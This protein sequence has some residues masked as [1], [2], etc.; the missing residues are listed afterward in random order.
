MTVYQD[1]DHWTAHLPP[2]WTADRDGD[3]SVLVDPAGPGV[4]QITEVRATEPIPDHKLKVAKFDTGEHARVI[5]L[6]WAGECLFTVCQ[7]QV[8]IH[9]A[10]FEGYLPR[11]DHRHRQHTRQM[12]V[13]LVHG[14]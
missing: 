14:S 7:S 9:L 11:I 4:V 10:Q 12:R 1:A 13:G 8:Q 6:L 5:R 3:T 2:R